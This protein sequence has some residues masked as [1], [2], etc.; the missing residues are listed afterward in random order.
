MLVEPTLY[1]LTFEDGPLK[2]AHV[3]IA[4]MSIRETWAYNDRIDGLRGQER[5]QA[6]ANTIAP[7]ITAW[8][9]EKAPG[10]AWPLTLDG[11]QSLPDSY[12]VP[13]MMGWLKAINGVP[14]PTT[15]PA[16]D[17]TGD[18]DGEDPLAAL[19]VETLGG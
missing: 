10:E 7:L 16:A 13:I 17:E 8:D 15:P 4:S 1:N 18:E 11:F 6:I 19:P 3:T 5:V 9:L 14:D 12:L 2:G